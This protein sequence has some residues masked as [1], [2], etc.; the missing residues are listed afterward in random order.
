MPR[1]NLI[2]VA[3]IVAA[4]VATVLLTRTPPAPDDPEMIRFGPVIRSHR[5]LRRSSYRPPESPELLRGAMR[6]MVESLDEYSTYVPPDRVRSFRARLGGSAVCTGLV[7]F[8]EQDAGCEVL[9]SL[10]GS[11]AHEAGVEPGG[12]VTAVD[13]NDV[14]DRGADDVCRLLASPGRQAVEVTVTGDD[15][16]TKDYTLSRRPIEVESVTGVRRTDE[17]FWVYSLPQG[18]RLGCVRVGEFLPATAGLVQ[19]ALRELPGL[20]GLV[21]DLRDNP[22]GRLESGFATADLFLNDG[23]VFTQVDAS[24]RRRVHSARESGTWPDVPMAVLVNE[25]TAS[26]AE[27]VAGSLQLRRRAVLVG[28]RTRGKGLIQSMIALPGNMGL[29]NITTGE[30]FIGED[31]SITRRVGARTW[32]IEPDVPCPMA[33]AAERARRRHWLSVSAAPPSG[34]PDNETAPAASATTRSA[35]HPAEPGERTM[36]LDAQFAEA[37]ALLESPERM[38]EILSGPPATTAPA[39]PTP[40]AGDRP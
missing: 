11:P 15:G 2:W 24:G 6:G 14:S 35:S 40:T 37:V 30:F 16:R 27:I 21:L 39:E 23:A 32:G 36:A 25:R 3:A 20:K 26:A 29:A 34:E 13:G 7:L 12:F 33:P 9:G 18:R 38:R 22:G 1:R 28:V 17:G 10:P 19:Q 5:V 31:L 4:G 8:G